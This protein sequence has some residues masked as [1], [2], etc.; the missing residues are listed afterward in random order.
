MKANQKGFSVVEVL[1]VIVVVGLLGAVGW[2]IYDR[3]KDKTSDSTATTSTTKTSTTPQT[4]ET[5]DPYKDWQLYCDTRAKSCLKY[6]QGWNLEYGASINTQLTSPDA[7]LAK[8]SDSDQKYPTGQYA[9]QIHLGDTDS[10]YGTSAPF[11]FTTT[12]IEDVAGD[13]K[14]K[15][16]GGYNP[17]V[18][19]ASYSIVD[20]AFIQK[21]D[22]AVGKTSQSVMNLSYVNSP[23]SSS[24]AF[25][26]NDASLTGKGTTKNV[27]DWF[28]SDYAKQSLL[29]LK[30]YKA[31]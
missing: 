1:I 5:V 19:I 6:P 23:T 17:S 7:K 31:Q 9:V 26:A 27:T 15:V 22:L 20:T 28:A 25:F 3:Q 13:S 21:Y 30:S 14:L 24:Y 10:A 8:F 16:V 4:N 11:S 18:N 2:F 12:S 29:I